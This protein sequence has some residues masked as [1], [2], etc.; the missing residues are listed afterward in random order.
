MAATVH[1][2]NVPTSAELDNA[3]MSYIAQG[4][5]VSNRT[6]DNVSMFKK[7]EFNV[8]WAVI[9][10]FLC[11]LPLLVYCI[12]Y[13]AESD[14]MV[15]INIGE[16]IAPLQ[17]NGNMRLW[18]DDRRW[19]WDGAQWR[20]VVVELP[21]E[22]PR[23]DDGQ[24]WWDGIAWRSVVVETT[25][26]AAAAADGDHADAEVPNPGVADVET[27]DAG[28]ADADLADIDL[29]AAN[30]PLADIAD[31]DVADIDATAVPAT[32][33]PATAVP[34]TAVPAT[35]VPTPGSPV[36]PA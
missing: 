26:P 8:L 3:V 9:G 7:K 14:A 5:V 17:L 2:I 32:A 10:F 6:S 1:Q 34:A 24:L 20:D 27:A 30:L 15:V 22:A 25:A 35:A 19:W 4:Y 11:V 18:S 31:V 12:V 13:A 28:M 21:P 36:D 33:V 16:P 29:A 23:S